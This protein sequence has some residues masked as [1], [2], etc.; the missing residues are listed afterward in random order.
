[1]PTKSEYIELIFETVDPQNNYVSLTKAKWESHI[2]KD[3]PEL[4]NQEYITQKTVEEPNVITADYDN[5]NR[6]Y[7]REHGDKVLSLWG[8]M[9][10]VAV[11]VGSASVSSAYFRDS[12]T[13]G[14]RIIWKK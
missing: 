2:I 7:Y 13:T 4:I 11:S 3:H 12:M 14:E 6:F 5:E 1:M 9:I 10:K 8:T